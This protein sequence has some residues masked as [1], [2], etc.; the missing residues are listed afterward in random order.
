MQQTR[1]ARKVAK[2]AVNVVLYAFIAIC[3]FVVLLTVT[4][5][6]KGDDAI[7]LFGTQ[8]RVVTSSSMEKSDQTD[9]SGFD[10]KDI[11]L[12][13]MVFIDVVPQ[14]EAQ[15]NAWYAQ[16]K[17]GDVLTFKYV[18]VKQEVI[19]HR[20]V[21]IEQNEKGGYTID[22]EGDN[23]TENSEVLAQTIDTSQRNSPNYVI[24]KVKGQN[25]PVGLV[26]SLLKSRWGLIFAI[27]VPSL[28]ILILEI[29]K[30]FRMFEA[31]KR[32]KTQNKLE[33]QQGK[34]ESQQSELELLRR[35]LEELEKMQKAAAAS[36]EQTK[37]ETG[38]D[39][40]KEEATESA[41]ET[42]AGEDPT[43]TDANGTTPL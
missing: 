20:I 35:R 32:E 42:E 13:S 6:R 40:P 24:G 7:T 15:A 43:N 41:S 33:T 2:V 31:D 3:V 21:R 39:P 38:E 30:I 17:V 9:V 4:G 18:Y 5:K 37:E 22:L 12:R 23:K 16:L 14:D 8:M 19:T 27:I 26:V 10:V 34:I 11:P 29:L 28:I 1:T 36:A 25:Y